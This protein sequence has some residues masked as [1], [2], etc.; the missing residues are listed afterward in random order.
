M[1]VEDGVGV[2]WPTTIGHSVCE[3]APEEDLGRLTGKRG[4]APP[5]MDRRLRKAGNG[6]DR[7]QPP[8]VQAF[9]NAHP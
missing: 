9:T 8:R 7:P 6:E 3:K 1:G 5:S 2:T 4:T